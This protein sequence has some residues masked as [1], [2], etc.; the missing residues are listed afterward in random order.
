MESYSRTVRQY[1]RPFYLGIT[2]IFLIVVLWAFARTF[3][4]KLFFGTPSLPL[5]L[6][7]H[8][9]AMTG[10]VVLLVV[11]ASLVATRH[12]RWHRQV[13]VFGAAWAGLVVILGSVTT[14][15]AAARELQ[16]HSP[17]AGFQV[18]IMTLDMS[19]MALFAA[20]VTAAILMRDRPDYHKRFMLLTIGCM[21]P[22]ALA[23]L[24]V[25]FIPHGLVRLGLDGFVVAC[26]L[27]DTVRYRRLHP[28]LG[29]GG[30]A[31]LATFYVA[32]AVAPSPAWMGFVSRL[33]G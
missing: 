23:R 21:L 11:Q 6:H 2:A 13:G 32:L 12:V 25:S 3:Y 27:I 17:R 19:Q 10:W 31:L 20:F 4:L 5:L 28:A 30:L 24:H 29:W 14:L 7:V 26:V 1:E 15:H 8:A 22:D 16:A 18:I 33:L 9:L